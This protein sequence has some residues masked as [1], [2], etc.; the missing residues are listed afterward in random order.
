MQI[1]T[2]GSINI[3]YC[4]V[5]NNPLPSNNFGVDSKDCALSAKLFTCLYKFA[6]A[7]A[8]LIFLGV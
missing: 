8:V 7:L 6:G 5:D 4:S 2:Y 3:F 1:L